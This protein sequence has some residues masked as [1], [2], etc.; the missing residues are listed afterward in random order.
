MHDSGRCADNDSRVVDPD[1]PAGS[2]AAAGPRDGGQPVEPRRFDTVLRGYDRAQVDDHVG[3]LVEENAAL[4]QARVEADAR[5]DAAEQQARAAD[6]EIRTLRSRPPSGPAGSEDGF[7]F[8]AEKLLR[9]AEQEAAD[10]RAVAAREASALLEQS[11]AEAEHHRH[12]VEQALIARSTALEGQLA[13]RTAELQERERQVAEKL[14]EARTEVDALHETARA[15]ADHHRQQAESAAQA[16]R[17]R[18]AQDA[19]RVR[20]QA[21]QEVARLVA[22]QNGIRTELARV[23]DLLAGALGRAGA[24]APLGTEP[25]AP[26]PTVPQQRDDPADEGRD[27]RREPV[28]TVGR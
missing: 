17:S 5:R 7:G 24:D 1:R 11:R 20:E 18:A 6:D 9:F 8:R 12:E 2:P 15:A 16:L 14:T 4:H 10:A 21:Q 28:R 13:Q 19:H 22:L 3:R 26:L 27:R 25:D 23:A